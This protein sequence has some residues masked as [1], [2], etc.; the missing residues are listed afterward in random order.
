MSTTSWY[1]RKLEDHGITRLTEPKVHPL[2]RSNSWHIRGTE[3]DLLIDSGLGVVSLRQGHPD[4]FDRD[5][6]LLLTHGHLDHIGSA[7]EFADRW[8]HPAEAQAIETPRPV[9]L[10]SHRY[11][12]EFR[13]EMM[14][15]GLPPFG[16]TLLDELP[17]PDYDVSSY[18]IRAA[19]ATGWLEPGSQI[20]TGDRKF[21]VIHLP[22][23]SPG[24]VGFFEEATGVLFAGDAV[25]DEPLLDELPGSDIPAYLETMKRLQMLDVTL[26]HAGHAESFGRRRLIELCE[27]YVAWRGNRK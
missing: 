14:R 21:E 9:S 16:E 18:A 3:R 13:E 17:A 26:V 2:L 7:H 6:L 20:S 1:A 8:I 25:Y 15:R 23:H 5:P 19:P 11:P 24:S 4:L 12:I 27:A 22:G 10:M